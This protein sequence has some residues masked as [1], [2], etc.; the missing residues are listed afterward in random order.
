MVDPAVT[1]QNLITAQGLIAQA[2]SALQ[3][4]PV[5]VPVPV[6]LSQY[7][8]NLTPTN[9]GLLGVGV[10]RTKLP[11]LT[12][13]IKSGMTIIGKKITSIVDLSNLQDVTLERCWMRPAG[14]GRRALILGNHC[15][16][17]DS[18]IDGSAMPSGERFGISSPPGVNY[19]G[20]YQI[21][22]VKVT[23]VSIGAE[24][25]GDGEGE[26]TDSYFYDFISS[27]GAHIDGVTRRGG[28]GRL[29][30]ARSRI[31]T[32]FS[33]NGGSHTTGSFFLQNTWGG[34]IAGILLQDSYLEGNGYCL[35]LENK[36]AGTSLGVRNVRV[37][38]TEYGVLSKAGSIQFTEWDKVYR[39]DPLKP[40]FAGVAI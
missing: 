18:D 17:K 21:Q 37:R 31:S 24:I 29:L 2:I 8:W 13:P 27:G 22:H 35:A 3:P 7:G 36:G 11:I 4:V 12:E 23:G 34:K 28:T 40:D 1:I 6:P 9:T 38:S 25:D 20:G 26:I 33:D 19:T 39:Y 5:P 10:D 30:I 15:L 14:D 32:L 16:I